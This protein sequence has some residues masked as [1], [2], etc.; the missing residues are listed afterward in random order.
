MSVVSYT[1]T[2][3]N[4]NANANANT[5]TFVKYDRI[6]RSDVSNTF[7]N[8]NVLYHRKLKSGVSNANTNTNTNTNAL[9]R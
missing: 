4:V 1:Y 3:A 7:T 2:N 8:M 6:L 9:Y 5:I